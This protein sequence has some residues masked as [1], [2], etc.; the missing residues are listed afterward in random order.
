MTDPR[1]SEHTPTQ[2]ALYT[3]AT[4]PPRRVAVYRFTESSGVTMELLDPE[5][6]KV[7]KQYYERG[8]DL[9]KERRMVLPSEGPLYMRA[10]L[11]PFR[12]T[13]YTLRDESDQ[14]V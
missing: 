6:S 13:Y 11:Q 10:L 4:D 14:S 5:W 9:P 7:A 12:T 2:V 8:V 1:T 3:N